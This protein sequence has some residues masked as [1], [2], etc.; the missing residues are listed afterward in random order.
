MGISHSTLYTNMYIH[1]HQQLKLGRCGESRE[2]SLSP[3]DS[4]FEIFETALSRYCMLFLLS[5]SL[6]SQQRKPSKVECLEKC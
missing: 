1:V 4:T 6:P 3:M 2:G 5:T